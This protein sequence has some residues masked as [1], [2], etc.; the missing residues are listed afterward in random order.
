[1]GGRSG[2]QAEKELQR[3]GQKSIIDLTSR[4]CWG[5]IKN[6]DG[7]NN[8]PY[9]YS[10]RFT[11]CFLIWYIHEAI[12]PLCGQLYTFCASILSCGW[13]YL[14][15]P[16]PCTPTCTMHTY[17]HLCMLK[18][19]WILEWCGFPL[20]CCESLLSIL[21]FIFHRR[22]I[23]MHDILSFWCTK[24]FVWEKYYLPA[25]DPYTVV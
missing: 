25:N 7:N 9:I 6:V 21:L 5:N 10:L 15:M 2:P 22:K 23:F 1:M 19:L 20:V 12:H 4:L 14:P 16:A 17:L 24:P 8:L 13:V 11:C 18:L 3:D